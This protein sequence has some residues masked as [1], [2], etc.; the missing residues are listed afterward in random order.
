MPLERLVYTQI[1]MTLITMMTVIKLI[2]HEKLR[3]LY[4]FNKS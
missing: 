2:R 3:W 4:S 1:S